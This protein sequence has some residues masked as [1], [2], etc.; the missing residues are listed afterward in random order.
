MGLAPQI[1]HA[2]QEWRGATLHALDGIDALLQDLAF[3]AV[4]RRS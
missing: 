3:A 2:A 4:E 1:V